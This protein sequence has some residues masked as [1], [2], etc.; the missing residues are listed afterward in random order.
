MIAIP[1]FEKCECGH[2]IMLHFVEDKSDK[3]IG[4]IIYGCY[5]ETYQA[6][7]GTV[8]GVEERG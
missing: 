8:A 4:C 1:E 2:S 6:K 5:C 7:R 3:P